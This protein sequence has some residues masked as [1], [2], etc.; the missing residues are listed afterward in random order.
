M[1]SILQIWNIFSCNTLSVGL[2]EY[3]EALESKQK[4]CS[5]KKEPLGGRSLLKLLPDRPTDRP[6]DNWEL[7]LRI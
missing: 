2:R 1:K 7:E 3:L 5:A 4:I 6:T